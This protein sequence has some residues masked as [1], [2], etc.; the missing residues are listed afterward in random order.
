MERNLTLWWDIKLHPSQTGWATYHKVGDLWWDIKLHPSQTD[1]HYC[2]AFENLCRAVKLHPSQT[3]T[4][5]AA[6]CGS[7]LQGY[8]ITPFSSTMYFCDKNFILCWDVKLHPS[9]TPKGS[10]RMRPFGRFKIFFFE[11]NLIF[12]AYI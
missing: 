1:G 6:S 9:Q 5:S 4:L 12:I 10:R 7:P 8:Q 11:S 3:S 2:I